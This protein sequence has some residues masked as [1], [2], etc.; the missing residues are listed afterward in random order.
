MFIFKLFTRFSAEA[1]LVSTAADI[2]TIRKE[3]KEFLNSTALPLHPRRCNQMIRS[4]YCLRKSCAC[5][6]VRSKRGCG[7]KVR[8]KYRG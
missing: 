4:C 3:K 1:S 2:K 5:V 7:K 8:L 6:T